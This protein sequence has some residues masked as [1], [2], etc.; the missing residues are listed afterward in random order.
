MVWSSSTWNFPK[1]DQ[2]RD[3][4][5]AQFRPLRFSNRLHEQ[6]TQ[7]QMVWEESI[8]SYVGG[9]EDILRRWNNHNIPNHMQMGLFIEGLRPFKLMKIVKEGTL[10]D[11]QATINQAKLWETINV[12]TYYL[13]NSNSMIRF[14]WTSTH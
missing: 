10:V 4:F 3:E 6:L 13:P 12:I 2:L 9:M 1:L 5:L 14:S 7:I 11:L 8:T